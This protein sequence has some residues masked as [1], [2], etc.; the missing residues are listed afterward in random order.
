M[1]QPHFTHIWQVLIL[2]PGFTQYTNQICVLSSLVHFYNNTAHVNYGTNL[3][4]HTR[5]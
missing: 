1:P 2:D 3:Y 4:V 5:P